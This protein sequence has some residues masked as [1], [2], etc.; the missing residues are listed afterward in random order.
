MGHPGGGREPDCL[1]PARLAGDRLTLRGR[2]VVLLV[3]AG[4]SGQRP[5]LTGQTAIP[6]TEQLFADYLAE[7]EKETGR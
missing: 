1:C 5:R 3:A 6:P 4:K 7:R 2:A